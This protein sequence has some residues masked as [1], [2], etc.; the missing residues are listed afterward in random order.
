MRNADFR[1]DSG[2]RERSRRP[3][4][5]WQGEQDLSE[6]VALQQGKDASPAQEII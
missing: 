5:N 2:I 3:W 4:Q 6:M 1:P